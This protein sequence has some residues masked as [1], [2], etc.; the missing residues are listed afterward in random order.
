MTGCTGEVC[1]S[2]TCQYIHT[3]ITSDDPHPTHHRPASASLRPHAHDV[4]VMKPCSRTQQTSDGAFWSFLSSVFSL[5]RSRLF[6]ITRW[7][8]QWQ[9]TVCLFILRTRVHVSVS[10]QRWKRSLS[11][12]YCRKH[13]TYTDEN[14]LCLRLC[15]VVYTVVKFLSSTDGHM[16]EAWTRKGHVVTRKS[17]SCSEFVQLCQRFLYCFWFRP[18]TTVSIYRLTEFAMNQNIFFL[19]KLTSIEDRHQVKLQR[20][21]CLSEW[22]LTTVDKDE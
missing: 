17:Q 19:L 4:L 14:S 1:T 16:M 2:Y 3:L 15:A 21:V 8:Q 20:K 18:S 11:T 7:T 5:L 6:Q 10:T 22:R 13:K 9:K 12:L